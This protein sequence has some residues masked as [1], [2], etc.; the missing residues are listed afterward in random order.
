MHQT[1]AQVFYNLAEH[2]RLAR[3]D[4]LAFVWDEKP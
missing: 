2:Y 1:P 4:D 3:E